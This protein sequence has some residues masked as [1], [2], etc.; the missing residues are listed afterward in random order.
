MSDLRDPTTVDAEGAPVDQGQG[1]GG[2]VQTEAAAGLTV[3]A[4][5]GAGAVPQV[6][7]ALEFENLQLLSRFLMGIAFMG[8]D[9]LMRRLRFSHEEM[10]ADP[11]TLGSRA[12]LEQESELELLRYLSIGLFARGRKTVAHG[13][14]RGV[15]ISLGATKSVLGGAN[16]LTDNRLMRPLRRSV[17]AR[18]RDLGEEA[19]VV[20]TEG[21]REEQMARL[22]ANNTV[23]EIIDE[24]LD[25]ISE[26][27]EVDQ[28]IKDIV[29]QQTSGLAGVVADN[30]RT[31]TV[32][33]DYLVE[34]VARRL[35]RRKPRR[36]LSPSPLAG[37][38][39]DMYSVDTSETGGPD[40]G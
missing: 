37:E 12:D 23:G 25:F 38:L 4:Q 19:S 3:A 21:L 36:E 18:A 13:L 16:R 8:S 14:R 9:A 29:G 26:S 6:E 20:M 28:L 32:T 40:H 17:A 39:Q 30:T 7:P 27:P 24:V 22:L 31:V 11:G 33:G 15:Q 34:A 10:E 35:L 1:S 2:S 5:P